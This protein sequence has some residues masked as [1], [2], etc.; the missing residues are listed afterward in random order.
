MPYLAPYA[1]AFSYGG[2]SSMA[3]HLSDKNVDIL[4]IQSIL[5]HSSTRST[6]PYIHP[7]Q[8]RIRKAMEK[9][10]SV[11]FVKELIRKGELNLRFQS[12]RRSCYGGVD[13][14]FRPKIE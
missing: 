4:V 9:L 12:S 14:S 1:V 10:P 8:D 5:G 6:E 2:T 3:S 13:K 11:I 7:S